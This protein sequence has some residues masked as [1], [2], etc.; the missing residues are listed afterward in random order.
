MVS[1]PLIP[2]P[3]KEEKP[4]V[5]LASLGGASALISGNKESALERLGYMIQSVMGD[6]RDDLDEAGRGRAVTLLQAGVA[7]VY[8]MVA[9]EVAGEIER[10][11][12]TLPSDASSGHLRMSYAT[13]NGWLNGVVSAE[14]TRKSVVEFMSENGIPT[15]EDQ[16]GTKPGYL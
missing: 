4:L 7:E 11:M 1:S 6:I 13:F 5:T 15:P 12:G 10:L 9:P 2:V 8:T 14:R 16:D 3:R